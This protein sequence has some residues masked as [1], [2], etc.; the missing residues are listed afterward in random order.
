MLSAPAPKARRPSSPLPQGRCLGPARELT[1]VPVDRRSCG[2][3]PLAYRLDEH[4]VADMCSFGEQ[5]SSQ[6]RLG[7][8][9]QQLVDFTYPTL[10]ETRDCADTLRRDVLASHDQVENGVVNEGSIA[11]TKLACALESSPDSRLPLRFEP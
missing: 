5:A 11:I 1:K 9:G 8:D 3:E 7:V 2:E 4:R 6:I 10:D